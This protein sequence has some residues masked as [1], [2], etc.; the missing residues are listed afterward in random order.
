MNHVV[1]LVALVEV[2]GTKILKNS[3]SFI[4]Q[5]IFMMF[6]YVWENIT[7]LLIVL[8]FI[9]IIVHLKIYKKCIRFAIINSLL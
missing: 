8:K 4:Q 2:S 3:N 1:L 5:F 9:N 7:V 6:I